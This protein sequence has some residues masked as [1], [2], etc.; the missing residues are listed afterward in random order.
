MSSP[1][2][3]SLLKPFWVVVGVALLIVVAM[4][5]DV[6]EATRQAAKIGW[7]MALI[8]G[9]HFLSFLS[10]LIAWHVTIPSLPLDARWLY[11]LWKV[12]MA[13]EALNAVV[14]A[15]GFGGE[16][17][18]AVLLKRHFGIGYREGIA[19]LILSQTIIVI[20]LVVFL[21]G[22]FGLM[23]WSPDLPR[24]FDLA[25][26]FGLAAIAL[27]V[28]VIVALQ[29]IKL[30]DIL[31]PRI[32]RFEIGRRIEETLH[33]VR[34]VEE[35]LSTFYVRRRRRFAA[36]LVFA[37]IPWLIGVPEIYFTAYFLGHPISLADAWI[38]EAAVQLVRTGLSVVPAGLGAQEGAFL[39]IFSAL[40]GTPTL[41]IS[42]AL[43]RRFREIVW[44]LWGAA[45]GLT[46][47][48]GGAGAEK[49]GS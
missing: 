30:T 31:G 23:L 42:V 11:R 35:R 37:F 4:H 24:S 32:A 34:D 20:T 2:R 15:A 33:H 45:V 22:G 13:G 18:K 27:G 7:G 1:A 21:A 5:V 39:V 43:V 41:G 47:Y 8:L 26:A 17:L 6:G 14:P 19:S 28:A 44:V 49:T 10:D 46:F 25:A 36:A 29:N 9:L 40:T 38:V 16:P 12:R 48:R 3:M